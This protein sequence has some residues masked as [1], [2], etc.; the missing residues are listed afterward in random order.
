MT[1]HLE[2]E[3][4]GG[5]WALW[6]LWE[7]QQGVKLSPEVLSAALWCVTRGNRE[8]YLGLTVRMTGHCGLAWD[9]QTILGWQR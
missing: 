2:R 3:Q 5:L 1:K 4:S 8:G 7:V 6:L 9:L